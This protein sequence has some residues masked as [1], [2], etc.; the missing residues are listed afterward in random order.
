MFDKEIEAL[1]KCAEL[2]KELDNESRIRVIKYLIEKFGI[3]T[4]PMNT[5]TPSP[6]KQ[7]FILDKS[8]E[9]EDT[10]EDIEY[11]TLKELL[12]KNYPKNETEW[13]LCFAFYNSKYGTD[14][15]TRESIIEK[16][17]ESKKYS[18][19]AKKNLTQNIN[20]CIKKNWIKDVNHSDYI[21][22]PEG[23]EYAKEVLSG[24]STSKEIK[25][26]KKTKS[27][28]NTDL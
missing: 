6:N 11:P 21:L 22:K 9:E 8:T 20:A 27:G 4:T 16:Y 12:I 13:I 25:R 1:A 15:F 7:Q 23:I 14:T 26:T 10:Y 2:I 17:N 3:G 5:Y 19:N 24:N 28:N 18:E